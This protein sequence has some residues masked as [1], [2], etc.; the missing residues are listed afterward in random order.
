M[1]GRPQARTIDLVKDRLKFLVKTSESWFFQHLS[2]HT[3]RASIFSWV[4][5]S[6]HNPHMMLQQWW[7]SHW[8]CHVS[9]SFTSERAKEFLLLLCQWSFDF[10]RFSVLDLIM[11]WITCKTLYGTLLV[12]RS[13]VLLLMLMH[14]YSN[15]WSLKSIIGPWK[16]LYRSFFGPYLS[17]LSD[18]LNFPHE[19]GCRCTYMMRWRVR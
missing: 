6:P 13:A 10:K 14:S 16:L 2:C 17:K 7:C 9:V 19:E 18:W 12:K 4:R 11:T 15:S 3:I 5:I 1:T 8:R